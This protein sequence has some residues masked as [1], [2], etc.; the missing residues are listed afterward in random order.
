M[1]AP[2]APIMRPRA[3][4]APP[5]AKVFGV[6]RGIIR[7]A[8]RVVLYGP[9][10]IGKSTAAAMAPSPVFADLEEGT[11]D[12]NVRRVEGIENWADLRLWLASDSFS[13]VGTVVIDS[14]TR[15]EQMCIQ[16]VCETVPHEKGAIIKGIEDYGFGKGYVY[17]FEE[18]RRFLGDL[19]AHYRAGRHVVLIAHDSDG[20][21]PNPDGEDYLR[22]QPR[23]QT[24]EKSSIMKATM[25]WADHV[26]YVG[27]NMTSKDGKAKGNGT[28]TIYT[29]GSPTIIA[30]SRSL[31]PSPIPYTK[32]DATLWNLLLAKPAEAAEEM[33]L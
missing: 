27:Y 18:W 4:A 26:L 17:V 21:A 25:E 24:S 8:H 14:A 15:A 30:K 22:H 5:K 2:A 19:E 32:D 1:N 6:N 3:A 12:L 23:L 16:H 29:A 9:G 11:R 20:K 7:A 28:R 10:G 31:P 13:D 33:P